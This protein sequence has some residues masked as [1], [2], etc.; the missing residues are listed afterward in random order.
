[1][2]VQGCKLFKENFSHEFKI[3][4]LKCVNSSSYTPGK[5]IF[6]EEPA[7]FFVERGSVV[8]KHPIHQKQL[9]RVFRK[10]ENFGL[11]EFLL[12]I[13]PQTTFRAETCCKLM[14]ITHQ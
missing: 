13:L 6:I 14:Y 7:V 5:P 4:L 1:M 3:D 10:G 9:L 11:R 12:N 2:I 8:V